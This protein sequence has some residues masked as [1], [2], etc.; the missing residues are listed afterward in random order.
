MTRPGDAHRL[1]APR[2]QSRA[3]DRIARTPPGGHHLSPPDG[4]GR[5]SHTQKGHTCTCPL[6]GHTRTSVLRQEHTYSHLSSGRALSHAHMHSRPSAITFEPCAL[7]PTLGPAPSH[8]HHRA[9]YPHAHPPHKP[10]EP[11]GCGGP[12]PAALVPRVATPGFLARPGRGPPPGPSQAAGPQGGLSAIFLARAAHRPRSHRPAARGPRRHSPASRPARC[13]PAARGSPAA[14]AAAAAARDPRSP[15]PPPPA[16]CDAAARL[17]SPSATPRLRL[18]PRAAATARGR[19]LLRRSAPAPARGTPGAGGWPRLVL[20]PRPRTC[21][22]VCTCLAVRICQA[23]RT[24]PAVRTLP[25]AHTCPTCFSV[26]LLPYA[27]RG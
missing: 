25:A 21:L 5:M 4:N 26:L 22:S 13:V 12:R 27:P 8:A 18:R 7:T 17:P 15:P 20:R 16:Q 6:D 19:R 10:R 9:G 11:I 3:R 24:C 14:T 23:V 2:G 1:P